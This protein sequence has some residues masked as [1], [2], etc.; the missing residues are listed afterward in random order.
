M[1]SGNAITASWRAGSTH[2]RAARALAWAATLWFVVTVAGQLVFAAYVVLLYGGAAV[3]GSF[4]QWNTVMTH[5]HVAGDGVGNAATGIHLLMAATIM[6]SGALQLVPRLRARAPAF[7]RWNGRLYLVAAVAASVTGIYMI[8]W[9]GAVGD[10]VQHIGTSVNGLLV[11]AFAGMALQRIRMRDVAAHRRW[12][13]RLFLAV[14]GV[15][16]FRVGLMFWLAVNGGPAGFDPGTFRGPFLS[17][18]AFAQFLLPLAVLE[19]YLVCRAR[20]GAGAHWF[21][22]GVLSALTL[23]L[24]VGIAVATVGMWLPHM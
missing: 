19:T 17:F 16:F 15:W 2:G 7:H 11:L 22:A 4:G 13:M 20:G 21:M 1:V 6:L 24:G 3:R 12:A 10:V 5:G 9:R 18:L 14:S 8:W 23:A